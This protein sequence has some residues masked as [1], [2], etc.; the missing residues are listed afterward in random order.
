[1][2]TT[3]EKLSEFAVKLNYDDLPSGVV[4][5]AKRLVLDTLGCALS[6][7][8]REPCKIVRDTLIDI[9]GTP[10][11]TIIGSGTKTSCPNATLVN[12]MMA[13]YMCFNDTYWGKVGVG[14]PS[15]NIATALAVGERQHANG[16]EVINAI[17]L[18][19]ECNQRF[20]DVFAFGGKG[21][22]T[23]S[24]PFGYVAPIVAG[25]LLNLTEEEMT[26]AIGIGGSHNHTLAGVYGEP[27]AQISMMKP[28]DQHFAAQSGLWL[29]YWPKKVL[30]ARP[31]LL[32]VSIMSSV[33]MWICSL[34]FQHRANS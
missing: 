28:I 27:G 25:K 32:R 16:R 10:E 8:L 13:K 18:A 33:A 22:Q 14:H 7:Y 17:V 30:Q 24:I 20:A 23:V 34:S 26:N 1:M 31:R 11:C 29:P 2:A 6:G 4:D 5:H 15:D 9:G 12:G 21:W 3:S 19:Y